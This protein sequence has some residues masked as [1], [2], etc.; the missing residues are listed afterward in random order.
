VQEA[1]V[2]AREDEPDNKRL[3]VYYTARPD[4]AAPEA[5]ALRAHL[6]ASLPEYMIPAAFVRLEAM[7]LTANGKFDRRALPAPEMD[8]FSAR[9]YEPPVGEIEERLAAIWA[10]LLRLRRVGRRDNF[11]ELGGHSLLAV[12]MLSQLRQVLGADVLLSDLFARPVL[13]DFAAVVG[14]G[15]R[16]ALPPIEPASRGDPLPLSFAQQ[17]LW[18]GAQI[19]GAGRAY[20]IPINVRLRGDLDKRALKL[21][22]DRLVARHEAL[23]AA[24][25]VVEGEPVQ[26]VAGADVGFVLQEHDIEGERDPE[27]ALERLAIEESEIPFDLEAGPLARARLIRLADRDHVLLITLHHIIFDGWST[28]VFNRE[29]SALYAAIREGRPDPLPKLAIQYADYAIWQRRWLSGSTL[30]GHGDYWRRALAGAPTVLDLPTDRPRP[31][32]QDHAGSTVALE[33]DE[34]LVVALKALALRRGATLFMTLLAGWA[35]LLSRLSGQEDVVIGAAVANR[36]R[37]EIEPL[38]GFFVNSL[39]L[40]VDLS[41]DPSVGELLDRV[42]ACALEAQ[43]HQ[44]LPFERVVEIVGPPR[45][46]AYEPIF[47]T[48]F[49]WQNHDEGALDLPGLTTTLLA[50]PCLHAKYDLTLSLTEVGGRVVGELE[51]AAA[52][53][54]RETIERHAGYLGRLLTAMAADETRVIDRLPLLDEAERQRVLVAW[55]ATEADYPRDTCVHELFEAQAARTPEAIA[56]ACD[57]ERLTYAELN[58]KANGLA[59]H[60]RTVGLRPDDC[61][62]IALER[63]IELVVAQLA[64]LKCAAAYVPLDRSAPVRRQAFMIADCDARVI[65]TAPGATVPVVAG[66]RRIDVDYRTLSGSNKRD[67]GASPGGDAIAYV[68][69]TSG[70]TGQPKGVMAPHR[71]VA[72]LAFNNS[73]AEFRPTDRVAFASNPAFD[74]STMEVWGPLL[75]GGCVVVVDQATLLDPQRFKRW[76]EDHAISILWLTAGLFHQYADALAAPFAR[77]RILITG[78]DVVDPRMAAR[79]VERGP[80]QRLLNGYGPTETTTFAATHEIREVA[81]SATNIPIGRP[82]SNARIYI[83]DRHLEPVPIGATGEI[84]IGGA[85]VARGY[86]NRPEVTAQRFIASPFVEGDRL[87]RTGDLARYRPDG[88]IEF[89]GRDDFQVKIRGFRIELG[90]I[91]ARLAEHAG[92]LAAVVLAREEAPGEKR[93]VAYYTARRDV[94]APEA[95]ALRAHLAANLPEYMVPAAFVRLEAMPLTA[96]GKLDRRA[97]P[98]P[99]MD[100]FSARGYEPPSGQTE[101]RLAKIWVNLLRVER[102]GRHDNFFELGGHSLM[103]VR[104]MSEIRKVFGKPLALGVLFSQPTVAGLAGNLERGVEA[105]ELMSVVPIRI[106]RAGTPLFLIHLIERDLARHLGHRH[107]VYG[108]T[109]G[110]AAAGSDRDA[111]WPQDI[112]SFAAHYIDQMRSVQ[113]HGPYRLIGHSLGGL[114]A[115][116]MARVLTEAGE[117]VEFLGLLDCEAPDPNRRPRRLPAM[118]IGLNLIRT[119][120]RVWVG[121]MNEQLET[122]PLV[123][124]AKI[125]LSPQ[126]SNFRLR[127]HAVLLAS[128]RPRRYLGRVHLFKAGIQETSIINES[129]PPFELSW[130][131]LAV[132]GLDV[133]SLPGGHMEIVRDP[134][135]A[136]TANAIESALDELAQ[137]D[138][139][140]RPRPRTA[141]SR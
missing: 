105:P 106:G 77:L 60:L 140:P 46:L 89:L 33:F 57:G 45:S 122:I 88:T 103:G 21:A 108:L 127:L 100:A 22:L 110:L 37:V 2:L 92:V 119:P 44:D 36:G 43:A 66:V 135:A 30:E 69:Y 49:A 11:F 27:G 97:L 126:Q 53:F 138:A 52:L 38:I 136:V 90:E 35:A 96:N 86:L 55:N 40:R 1:V 54:D 12:R 109:F 95:K 124:W 48:M 134:L 61:A 73:Y 9:G 67:W 32:R 13:A 19:E 82:I 137:I 15:G 4:R 141:I 16:S 7:P 75:N 76:L 56:V 130:R 58:A 84:L 14:E 24:F 6:A 94:A 113:P 63:S 93:L 115:Y 102:V 23:R 47:Q 118:R 50:P 128:Y 114:I 79:V 117:T 85:G 18:F 59:G 101:E 64:I 72:R 107:S 34:R 41:G 116:E 68:M 3:V 112:E 5:E 131:D 80:P 25:T 139:I 121:R 99:E 91:E 74:A 70:S 29:L 129:S 42:K 51:Y 132:G 120:A 98:A 104:L 125:R 71:A 62:A 87:Y 39:A 10:D 26:R 8:A 20:H 81:A 78:G 123:R 133:Q 111:Q 17:R 28:G 31:A 65:L 83:L